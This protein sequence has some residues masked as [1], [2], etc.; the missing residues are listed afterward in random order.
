[1]CCDVWR[2][3]NYRSTADYSALK[4]FIQLPHQ[5]RLCVNRS[6]FFNKRNN[7]VRKE[8]T[9]KNAISLEQCTLRKNLEINLFDC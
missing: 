8:I 7:K 6:V 3:L 5:K 9:D 4:Q 1:M 2:N